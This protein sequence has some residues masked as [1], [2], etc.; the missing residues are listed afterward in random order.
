[1]AFGCVDENGILKQEYATL[2]RTH[3]E[4]DSNIESVMKNITGVIF[5]GEE[6]I[7][8]TLYKTPEL[9]HG[10]V[11][12]K[13]Y[14]ATRNI[15][16]YL[17]MSY[18]LTKNIKVMGFCRGMQMR[19]V[20]SGASVM[21]DIPTYFQAHGLTCQNEHRNVKVG[22]AYRDYSQH[23]VTVVPSSHLSSIT[24]KATLEGC[25]SWHHQALLSVDNT[26][27]KVTGTTLTDTLPMIEAIERTDKTYAIGLQFHPEAALVKNLENAA[28]KTDYMS[29]DTA[30]S[31]FKDFVKD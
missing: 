23:S 11:V 1:M 8:P 5:N 12:E 4:K 31:F 21:Q 14:N 17:T 22:D 25:P 9:G 16:D 30:L 18:C 10:I 24:G 20:Y 7:S 29:A 28:N 15:S 27:L 26:A 2:V 19:G 3:A 13:D 6:D